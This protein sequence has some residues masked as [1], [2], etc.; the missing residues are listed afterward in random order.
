MEGEEFKLVIGK[1]RCRVQLFDYSQIQY[2]LEIRAGIRYKNKYVANSSSNEVATK[3]NEKHS[4]Y[5][6]R[7][8]DVMGAA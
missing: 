4:V 2:W 5:Y 1:K 7:V 8:F 3:S 6:G